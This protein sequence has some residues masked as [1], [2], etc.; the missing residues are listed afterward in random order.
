MAAAASARRA[1]GIDRNIVD[2]R[3]VPGEY[4]V[5]L[6]GANY[7]MPEVAAAMG[8]AQLERLPG[9]I[10]ARRANHERLAA[11]LG[12]IDEIETLR[13]SHGRF[14]SSYYCLSIL[15]RG[16]LETR[17]NQLIAALGR[18]GVGVSIYYPKPVPHL[19]YYRQKYGYA[20]NSFPVASRLSARSIA[21][22]VG[23]HLDAEDIEYVIASVKEAIGAVS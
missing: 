10:A 7:R 12:G 19:A 11:G 18:L 20:D 6:L 14:Q 5:P 1:F 4:D 13:S 17:R 21:L 15:L 23:P 22:P 9:F 2:R 8:L 16:P 3:P